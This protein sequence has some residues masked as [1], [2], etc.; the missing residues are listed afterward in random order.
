MA[1]YFLDSLPDFSKLIEVVL[2]STNNRSNS[3]RSIYEN[4]LRSRLRTYIISFRLQR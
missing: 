2:I 4:D 1:V 3:L